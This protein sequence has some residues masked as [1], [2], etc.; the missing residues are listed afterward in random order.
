MAA[1]LLET[2]ISL[3]VPLL[4]N[5]ILGIAFLYYWPTLLSLVSRAAPASIKATLMGA[6]FLTLF[7]GNTIIGRLG[8]LYEQMT[9]A[10]FWAM[11]A[12]IAAV[13]GVLALVLKRPL[14]HA[15]DIN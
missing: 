10:S 7:I 2:R 1:C 11:H 12:G 14:K 4:S 9:P 8:G 3:L 13:G 15:L 6:A 5:T